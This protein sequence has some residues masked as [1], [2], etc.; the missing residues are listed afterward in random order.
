MGGGGMGPALMDD[1]WFYGA[2]PPAIFTSI[3]AGR[4]NGMPA[5]GDRIPAQ[6]IWQLVAYVRTL[7]A[8]QRKDVRPSRPDA[9]QGRPG[10]VMTTPATPILAPPAPPPQ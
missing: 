3:A 5:F 4:P 8:L 2:D 10:P 9:M 7:G 6:Q 1:V